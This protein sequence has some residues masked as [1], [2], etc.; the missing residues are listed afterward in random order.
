MNKA[1]IRKVYKEK[2]QALS[3]G[4]LSR[5]SEKVINATLSSFPLAQKTVSLFLPIERKKEINTYTLWEKLMAMDAH[6]AVPKVNANKQ[7]L[8]HYLLT[9]HSQLELSSLGIPEPKSG[10]IIAAHKIDVVFVPLMAFDLKGN[11]VGY[12]G[13]FYD[14]FLKKCNSQ[15]IFI[16]LSVFPP[17]S[18]ISDVMGHDIPLHA[19]VTPDEVFRF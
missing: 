3:P 14:R 17:V 9:D 6:V 18:Q 12:G 10:K 7:D 2:R 11:R 8:K 16:G 1:D 4:D 19:C 15:C 5:R 13:G